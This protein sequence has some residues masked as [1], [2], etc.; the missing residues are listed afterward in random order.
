[1][2][3][4]LWAGVVVLGG[5]GSFLRYW[6]DA[7]VSH[8]FGRTF[9]WGILVINVS[10]A[11]ALGVVTGL[12]L[13]PDVALLAGTATVGAYTTFSTWVLDTQRLAEERAWR[14]AVVNLVV[15]TV[16][17]LAAVAGGL[18]VGGLFA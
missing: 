11:F 6:V 16:L 13:A 17:G 9:P 3:A 5:F 18:A 4:L 7:Q 15:S 12:A 14:A 10:G 1:M 8:R 2:T